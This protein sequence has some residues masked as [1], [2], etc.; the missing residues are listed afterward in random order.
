MDA[1]IA[2]YV[3]VNPEMIC[4]RIV[5]QCMPVLKPGRRWNFMASEVDQWVKAGNPAV[6]PT[7][8]SYA[9]ISQ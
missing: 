9:A 6:D 5:R 4:K 7:S 1:E 3:G 2:T 8:G